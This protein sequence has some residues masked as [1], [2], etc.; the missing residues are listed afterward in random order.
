MQS[1]ASQV[2][3]ER[4]PDWV[5]QETDGSMLDGGGFATIE[6]PYHYME[7]DD[8][9]AARTR[10]GATFS[11]RKH[12]VHLGISYIKDDDAR[13]GIYG[14]LSP[15]LARE[16]AWNLEQAAMRAEEADR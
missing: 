7:L 1:D 5:A 14:K 6:L 3:T 12:E 13:V 16:L 11:R 8:D 9:D 10:F 15:D 2:R 4:D